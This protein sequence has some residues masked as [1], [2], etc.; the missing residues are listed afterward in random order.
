M[1]RRSPLAPKPLGIVADTVYNSIREPAVPTFYEPI[2]QRAGSFFPFFSVAI[3]PTAEP[4]AQM[5][6]RMRAALALVDPDLKTTFRPMADRV[7][8]GLAR[9]RLVA[10]LSLCAGVMALVLAVIGLYGVTAYR[11]ARRRSELGIRMALGSTP[12]AVL[13]LVLLETLRVVGVGV[14]LGV[15][16]SLWSGQVIASL[17]YGVTAREPLII[18]GAAI[19]MLVAGLVSAC[20]PAYRASVTDPSI[21]LRHT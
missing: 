16:M 7:S 6:G 1:A 13:R 9:D 19:V 15:T 17:L 8:A 21:V 12:G 5:I 3:R 11:V 14:L 18:A 2:A 4:P 20:G 10:R